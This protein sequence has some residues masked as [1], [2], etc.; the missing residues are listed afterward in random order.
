MAVAVPVDQSATNVQTTSVRLTWG[1]GN[2]LQALFDVSALTANRSSVQRVFGFKQSGDKSLLTVDENISSISGGRLMNTTPQTWSLNNADGSALAGRPYSVGIAIGDSFT[3]AEVYVDYAAELIG[4][5]DITSKGV[6]GQALSGIADRFQADVVAFSPQFVI[7][8]GGINTLQAANADPVSGMM[9][10]MESM[11]DA[12]TIA[13]IEPVLINVG[14][15]NGSDLW[16]AD[17]QTWTEDFN[18]LLE[19]YANTNSIKILDIYSLLGSTA[20]PTTMDADWSQTDF[21]HP[22]T[23]G[24][25]LIGGALSDM[26][27]NVNASILVENSST[28][29]VTAPSNPQAGESASYNGSEWV[30]TFTG[31][32]FAG[33]TVLTGSAVDA[34]GLLSEAGLPEGQVYFF[35]NTA[36]TETTW[37]TLAGLTGASGDPDRDVSASIW[38]AGTGILGLKGGVGETGFNNLRMRRFSIEGV[39]SDWWRNMSLP[40]RAGDSCYMVFPQLEIGKVAS[41]YMNPSIPRAE[42][43]YTYPTPSVF[44]ATS[45]AVALNF[46]PRVSGQVGTLLSFTTNTG[47]SIEITG[48]SVTLAKAGQQATFAYTHTAGLEM[49]IQAYWSPSG[50]GIRAAD[51][52]GDISAAPF[53]ENTSA[54]NMV[55]GSELG[56]ANRAGV[57]AVS[58]AYPTNSLKFYSS[59]ESTDWM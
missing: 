50:M 51:W 3:F 52:N 24:Y 32:T 19:S 57:S 34:P 36:G 47:Y 44:S 38:V 23:L 59:I 42:T 17:R 14:A 20:D 21:L 12:A 8:Q 5:S 10:D 54:L 11:V 33:G 6:S 4:E 25:N 29:Y 27:V 15:W 39:A 18:T 30:S 26:L 22:N 7:I 53:A 40:M 45:G 35:D 1:Q 56:L 41:S 13:G 46:K 9:A 49:S 48:S 43:I 37:V 28:N 2:A 16:S 31:F 55:L 58:G